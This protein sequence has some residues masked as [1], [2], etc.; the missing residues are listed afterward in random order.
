[1]CGWDPL[2]DLD[3][4]WDNTVSS[5]EDVTGLNASDPL[6]YADPLFSSNYAVLNMDPMAGYENGGA[7]AAP[8]QGGGGEGGGGYSAPSAGESTED[9]LAAYFKWNPELAQQYWEL[10]RLY[11][12]KYARLQW[13]MDKRLMP[14][15][16]EMNR[17]LTSAE[18]QQDMSDVVALTPYMR[19]VRAESMSPEALAAE[20]MLWDQINAELSMGTELTQEQERDVVQAQRSAEAARGLQGGQGSA[21]RESVESALEGQRLL[22]ERQNK[23]M[24]MLGYE[25]S[26]TPDPYAAI[27]GRPATSTSMASGQTGQTGNQAAGQS[28]AGQSQ[29]SVGQASADYW[30]AQNMQ[31][32]QARYDLQLQLAAANPWMGG[33][34][35]NP[36]DPSTYYQ[37]PR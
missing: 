1:M 24:G 31:Q 10:T 33:Y 35:S 13:Q 3:E 7:A 29:Y 32:Q 17:N 9:I 22:A 25:H 8:A 15:Y 20:Q 37:Q 26:T 30:N 21:N 27:L 23:A 19:D 18:R 34:Y 2:G 14:K 36:Y 11:S 6:L 12:P 4:A 5:V 28:A 16:A